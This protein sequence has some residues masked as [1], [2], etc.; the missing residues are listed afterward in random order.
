MRADIMKEI[1][2]FNASALLAEQ[3]LCESPEEGFSFLNF[4]IHREG[5]RRTSVRTREVCVMSI[6]KK[7]EQPLGADRRWRDESDRGA[8]DDAAWS[9]AL[10]WWRCLP[11]EAF[12]DA[13]KA[14]LEQCVARISSTIEVWRKA[15]GGDAAAA[16]NIA[17][18]MRFPAA[19]T[20]RLDLAMTVLLCCALDNP[21]AAFVLSVLIRRM[22]LEDGHKNRIATSWLVHNLLLA[23]PG[24]RRTGRLRRRRSIAFQLLNGGESAS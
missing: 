8:A 14:R 9:G 3:E 19:V 21:G 4:E 18:F 11:A 12:D 17:L 20:P 6:D 5:G 1:Q 22:P 2:Q 7:S 15:I 23:H 10:S 16:V 13:R 24:L